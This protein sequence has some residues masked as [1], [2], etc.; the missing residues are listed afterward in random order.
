MAI[1]TSGSRRAKGRRRWA[2]CAA[3]APLVGVAPWGV[4][5]GTFD[6][7]EVSPTQTR[8]WLLP[9]NWDF[10]VLPAPADSIVFDSCGDG[11]VDLGGILHSHPF[12]GFK[13]WV[14]YNLTTGT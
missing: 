10:D 13:D 5:G 1:Q 8:M 4:A 3:V 14:S 11:T 12:L 9:V 7:G 6:G 2:L